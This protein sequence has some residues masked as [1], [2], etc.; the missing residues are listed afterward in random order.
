MKLRCTHN[1]IRLRVRKSDLEELA[2]AGIIEERVHFGQEI[3]FCFKLK[4]NL[5]ATSISATY[6]KRGLSVHLPGEDAKKWI[7]SNQVGLELNHD[8][9]DGESLHL[10][11]E[12]DFPCVDRADENKADTFWELV[13]DEPDVC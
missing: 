4:V 5:E 11:I 1:S 10:L 6:D 9:G 13:P 7:N 2:K 3:V 12:K 8:L